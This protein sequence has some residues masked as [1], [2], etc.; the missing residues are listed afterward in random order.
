MHQ[1]LLRFVALGI[2][3]FARTGVPSDPPPWRLRYVDL[4]ITVLPESQSIRGAVALYLGVSGPDTPDLA[5]DLADSMHIDSI[6][7]ATPGGTTPIVVAREPMRL[8]ITGTELRG[9]TGT[10]H[11]PGRAPAAER[12]CMLTIWYH[13][14][15]AR[16]AMA[17]TDNGGLPRVATYGLPMSAREWWPTIDS[18]AQKAD[19]ADIAITARADLV[20]ASNGRFVSRTA[21]ADR[22]A[23]TRW[24]VRYPIY[25]DVISLAI[26]NYV[27]WR[28]SLH[29]LGGRTV[30]L[31]FFVFPEDSAKAKADFAVVPRVL[32]F[33]EE[34]L[35]PYPFAQE[36]Y[37]IAE[38]ARPSFRE[39][40]TLTSLGASLIAGT[41]SSEEIIAHEVAHQWFGNSVS[42]T[43]WRDIWLNESFAE[44]MAWEWIRQA[45]GSAAF[46][47]LARDGRAADTSGV[48]AAADTSRMQSMF[49]GLTF[50]KGPFVL[51]MLQDV[52]GPRAMAR[53]L[54][55][56]ITDASYRH[57]STPAFELACERS[58]H[59][60]LRWFFVQ[61]VYGG[62][63]PVLRMS[64]RSRAIAGGKWDVRVQV[65]QLQ[66]GAPFRLPVTL[67]VEDSA[68]HTTRRHA[69]I[70]RS[71]RQLAFT[72]AATPRHVVLDMSHILGRDTTDR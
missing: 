19:S 54:H 44:F 52:I 6:R 47:S 27:T 34:W 22:T 32:H 39:H 18:P 40:Q 58:A 42:V 1:G 5:L 41:G 26:A 36:K 70:T 59:R 68:G 60:S 23:T 12:S 20:V 17:F 14:S 56:Y 62:S 46:D 55:T 2:G 28:D 43:S 71:S 57:G 69:W 24:A 63:V 29:S 4:A 66:S 37:G 72:T 53:A 33:Y 49:G 64:W 38:F 8:R 67:S 45:H 50:A 61:W 3:T 10:A 15:P 31:E 21:N 65:D 48:V 9:C 7:A 13:G 51:E 16:R 11:R 25:P 35:G 30:P